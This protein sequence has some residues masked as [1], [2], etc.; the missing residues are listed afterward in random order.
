LF[1]LMLVAW[2]KFHKMLADLA[3]PSN[4]PEKVTDA[5][6]TL[7]T[8]V[9]EVGIEAAMTKVFVLEISAPATLKTSSAAPLPVRVMIPEL[10]VAVPVAGKA[11]TLADKE[12]M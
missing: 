8:M 12:L 1:K 11:A 2:N 7:I 10:N 4:P 3:F 6:S 5:P 9:V